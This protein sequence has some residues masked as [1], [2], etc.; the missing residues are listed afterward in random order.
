M[1][2]VISH[3]FERQEKKKTNIVLCGRKLCGK[4]KGLNLNTQ[5]RQHLFSTISKLT[6]FATLQ[7][8]AAKT[9]N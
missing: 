5:H 4:I 2:F 1:S 9:S 7:T 8:H 6:S 3:D